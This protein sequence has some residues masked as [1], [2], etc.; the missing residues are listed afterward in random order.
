MSWF[1]CGRCRQAFALAVLVTMLMVTGAAQAL[2]GPLDFPAP[3]R[4]HPENALLTDIAQAGDRLVAVGEHGVIIYS[5]DQGRH[6]QQAQVPVSATL[7]AVTFVT[8]KVG[9]AVGHYGLVLHSTDG[10]KS[11]QI[12]L[13]G[14]RVNQMKLAQ[15]KRSLDAARASDAGDRKMRMLK[16]DLKFAKRAIK[17]GTS[18]PFLA[19]WFANKRIGVAVGGYGLAVRTTDGGQTWHSLAGRIDNPF[20]WHLYDLDTIGGELYLV[21]ERGYAFRSTDKGQTWTKLEVPY[22]GSFFGVIGA[23][24]GQ[25]VLI[26]GLQGHLYRSR[27]HGHSWQRLPVPLDT[28]LVGATALPNGSL[29][30]LSSAG[31]V[32]CR[33]PSA[34]EFNLV[35]TQGR[36][37][38]AVA[39]VSGGDVL[40]LTGFGGISRL[41]ISSGC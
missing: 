13:T 26:Y 5:G 16:L 37:L 10:G 17:Q 33:P 12:N 23:D 40:V 39:A 25:A 19:V 6:W 18:A 15:V 24:Q 35:S 1:N 36:P 38:T 32:A 30:V 8:P 27:D 34:Q 22:E 4:A 28:R 31:A 11:W 9:W 29:V 20:G 2:E 21:G 41:T 3:E 14:K 7:T